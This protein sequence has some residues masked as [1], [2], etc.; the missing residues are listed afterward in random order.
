MGLPVGRVHDSFLRALCM[1]DG[2]DD[3]DAFFQAELSSVVATI[4]RIT[5]DAGLS[6]EITQDAF[7]RTLMRWRRLRLYDRPGAWVRRVAIRDAVRAVQRR[8]RQ[9]LVEGLERTA[10]VPPSD[11]DELA[12]AVDALPP[13]QRAAVALYYLEDRPTAEVAELLSCSEATVRSHLRRARQRLD[14][15]LGEV[16][17][18]EE[19][20]DVR[21]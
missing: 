19:V 13:Q 6:E 5:G 11:D 8:S 18:P 15:L 2:G 12:A 4:F 20:G 16:A 10:V 1:G 7:V 14:E 21:K 17:H 9:E 3:F